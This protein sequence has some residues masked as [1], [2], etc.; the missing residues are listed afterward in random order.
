MNSFQKCVGVFLTILFSKNVD[1][2]G[3]LSIEASSGIVGLSLFKS[4]FCAVEW[5]HNEI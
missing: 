4:R 1:K 3:G 2:K 5:D